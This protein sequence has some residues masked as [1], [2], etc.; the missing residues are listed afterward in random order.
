M[1]KITKILIFFNIIYFLANKDIVFGMISFQ[2]DSTNKGVCNI[3]R[4]NKLVFGVGAF[5]L[6]AAAGVKG[7][8]AF[9]V[10]IPHNI[11]P[12]LEFLQ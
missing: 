6:L 7:I 8:K 5:S 9:G 3:I 12:F 2:S 11:L 10:K 1:C 4:K